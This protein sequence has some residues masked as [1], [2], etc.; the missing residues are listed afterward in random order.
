MIFVIEDNEVMARCIAGAVKKRLERKYRE[1]VSASEIAERGENY[2]EVSASKIAGKTEVEGQQVKIFHNAYEAMEGLAD[3][4]P[5]LIFL[6]ILLDGVDGFT[7]LNEIMSYEDTAKIPI[8]LVTSL[9]VEG[10][11]AEYG[12]RGILNKE[13]MTPKEIGEYV[14][15][16]TK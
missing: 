13:T 6:D 10:D 8:I 4:V 11:L 1:E 12:V 14:E 2:G 5:E 15:K 3:G 16:Y 7:F 9:K